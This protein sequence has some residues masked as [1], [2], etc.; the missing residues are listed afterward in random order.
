M[1]ASGIAFG[2]MS[3][4]PLYREVSTPGASSVESVL[5]V[6]S[7]QMESEA[8]GPEIE[9]VS[10]SG[11]LVEINEEV[12]VSCGDLESQ[13]TGGECARITWLYGLSVTEPT[14]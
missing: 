12:A 5:E 1:A 10:T 13:V 7:H 9:V 3:G 11:R 14:N 6:A 2:P 4:D 8:A